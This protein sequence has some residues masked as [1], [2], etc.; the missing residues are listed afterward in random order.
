MILFV[1]GTLQN[2]HRFG[3]I[4]SVLDILIFFISRLFG[5]LKVSCDYVSGLFS[6]CQIANSRR[7]AH[8][9]A[10]SP[11]ADFCPLFLLY[12]NSSHYTFS[13]SISIYYLICTQHVNM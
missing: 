11:W 7:A 2:W 10:L 12:V 13:I 8:L 1:F 4:I 9:I 5:Y 3:Q 6:R